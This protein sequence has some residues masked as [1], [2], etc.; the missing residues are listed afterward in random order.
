MKKYQVIKVTEISKQV[1]YQNMNE[2]EANELAY[3]MNAPLN[4]YALFFF[5]VEPQTI[6]LPIN[7][8]IAEPTISKLELV[9][10]IDQLKIS[11]IYVKNFSPHKIGY[12]QERIKE[13]ENMI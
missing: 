10:K 13:L 6:D 5:D 1:I 7:L 4:C 11:L 9:N 3:L 8:R 12:Y 2:K